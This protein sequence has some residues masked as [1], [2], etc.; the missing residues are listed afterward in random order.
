NLIKSQTMLSDGIYKAMKEAI[1]NKEL[2][3][4][5]A[6]NAIEHIRVNHDPEKKA[7]LLEQIY[8]DAIK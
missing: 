6:A 2:L 1:E 7:E 5:K 8:F 3:K 4:Q